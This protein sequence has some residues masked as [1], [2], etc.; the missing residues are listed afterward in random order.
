MTDQRDVNATVQE[1]EPSLSEV[2]QMRRDKL[3]ALQ[4]AG[5]DPFQETAYPVDAYAKDINTGNL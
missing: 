1:N 4:Q 5:R 3:S 2:L